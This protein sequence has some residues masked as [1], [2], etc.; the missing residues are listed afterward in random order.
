M[1]DVEV[2]VELPAP[3]DQR[4]D[5]RLLRRLRTRE[6]E[7]LGAHRIALGRERNRCVELDHLRQVHRVRRA[8][9]DVS[10]RERRTRLVGERVDDAE[11]GVREGH[12]GEALRVVHDR[13]GRRIA[14]IALDERVADHLHRVDGERVRIGRVRDGDDRLEV[15]RERV[16]ARVRAELLG[17]RERELRIDDRDVR[18]DFEV[19]DRELDA[20]GVVGDDREG[21]HLGRRAGGRGDRDELSLRAELRKPEDLAHVLE[22]RLRILVL[23]PHRLRRVDRRA[24]AHRDDPVGLELLHD[25]RTLHDRLHGGVGLDAG[26]DLDLHAGFLEVVL[27]ALQEAAAGHGT[28]ADADDRALAGERLE[29]RKGVLAMIDVARK[30]ET[31]HNFPFVMW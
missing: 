2:I 31:S 6:L 10:A 9:D 24:A 29:S 3:R 8:V 4:G 26:E 15:V 5:L 7:L 18:R 25:G 14:L 21:R 12:A 30:S 23:D 16:H 28:A 22:R 11:K 13:T 20:L 27:G 1:R 17:H 19:G